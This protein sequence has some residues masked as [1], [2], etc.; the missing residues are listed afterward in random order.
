MFGDGSQTRDYVFVGDVARAVARAA[1]YSAPASAG[2]DARAFNIGT[3]VPTSVLELA[4]ELMR[5]AGRDVPIEFAPKR[6]GEQQQSYLVVEKAASVLGWR[7]TVSLPQGLAQTYEW[8]GN[9][10]AAAGKPNK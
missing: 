2:M 9:R 8:F 4:R 10:A 7:P 5:A 6:P 1:G 3:G